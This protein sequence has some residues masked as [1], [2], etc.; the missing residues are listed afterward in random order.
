[1]EGKC[2]I[3]VGFLRG[4]GQVESVSETLL[5]VF[6]KVTDAASLASLRRIKSMNAT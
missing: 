6:V 4:Y 2:G 5:P 3:N 1:M